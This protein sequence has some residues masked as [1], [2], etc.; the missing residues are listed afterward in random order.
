MA[1]NVLIVDDS[2]TVRATLKKALK[3]IDPDLGEVYQASNGIEALTQMAS[4]LPDL[5]LIDMNMPTMTGMELLEQMRRSEELLDIPAVVI[6]T[7]GSEQQIESVT[8]YGVVG[9]LRKPFR[10]EQLRDVLIPILRLNN[11]T[12]KLQ[13]ADIVDG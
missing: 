4:S 10:P 7:E 2:A 5:V 6:T 1:H 13:P 9:Y 11:D 12:S 8:Q 3:L